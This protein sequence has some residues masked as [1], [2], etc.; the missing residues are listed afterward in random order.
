MTI[1][2]RKEWTYTCSVIFYDII[3]SLRFWS[4]WSLVLWRSIR[5]WSVCISSAM[6]SW[7]FS[8]SSCISPCISD[9]YW[10]LW[11]ISESRPFY[12]PWISHTHS[13]MI[14]HKTIIND[15]PNAFVIRLF[16]ISS[17]TNIIGYLL[18]TLINQL[19]RFSLNYFP[20]RWIIFNLEQRNKQ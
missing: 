6:T 7:L 13:L 8:C 10:W 12:S 16:L 14:V 15:I 20:K 9:S 17:I 18:I 2:I 1:I 3:L 11:R 19:E 5:F 4:R